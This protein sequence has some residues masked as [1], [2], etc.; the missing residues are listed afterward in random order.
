MS[1]SLVAPGSAQ[2]PPVP[3]GV[4]GFL[5]RLVALR[6]LEQDAVTGFL[7]S[8]ADRLADYDDVD[9]LGQTLV[10]CGLLTRYQLDRVRV[11]TTHGLVL[12]NYRVLESLGSG[13]MGLVFE[14]E[15]CLLR[16]RVAIKVVP[17]EED[18]PASVRQRFAAEMQLLAS[19]DHPHIVRALDAGE[20]PAGG[21]DQPGLSYLVMELVRGGDLEH[22]VNKHGPLPVEEACEFARQ[23]AIGLQAAHDRH[24]IHRDLKPSN[25]LRTF[26]GR[27]KL[28]DFGLARQCSSRLTDHRM[29]MGS[30]E[31]MPPEQ[32]HDAST[33]GQEAD[34]YGLGAVLFWLL[35][36]EPPHPRTHN[37]R[38]ALCQLR[39]ETPRLLRTL[40]ADAP[41]DLEELLTRMLERNP[42]R[43]PRGARAVGEALAHFVRSEPMPR[44]SPWR[45]VRPSALLVEDRPG[46]RVANRTVLE[47]LGCTPVIV[48]SGPRGL[49]MI[50][51]RAFELVL[52]DLALSGKEIADLCRRI[53]EQAR[54]DCKIIVVDAQ[55]ESATI[56]HLLNSGAD[57]VVRRSG[58]LEELPARVERALRIRKSQEEATRRIA[59]LIAAREALRQ[60]LDTRTADLV[61]AHD[62]LLFTMAK[63]AESRDGE[64]PGHLS[65]LQAYVAVLARYVVKEPGYQ[66]LSDSLFSNELIRCVPLHDIGKI[67][68]PEELLLKPGALNAAERILVETHPLIGDRILE[69][70][71]R[72]HGTSLEFLGMAR[73]IVRSHH[74]RWDGRGYP[75]RLSREAIPIAARLVGL[76]DVYDALRRERLHK[77]GLSHSLACM[78]IDERSPGQFDPS[79]LAAFRGC[80]S[81]FERIYVETRD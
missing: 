54:S 23:A 51:D 50:R 22:Y 75:D 77:P 39:E 63:M 1:A 4:S 81:E 48:D 40:R 9:R 29:L 62:A 10:R 35:T 7:E 18:V 65:R 3:A 12:G 61:R 42:A 30:L 57:D 11:G 15:H 68:L 14:A 49:E 25:L 76:A 45:L 20:V 31:F 2:A 52:L 41:A 43:R 33:V 71:A 70:L 72:E 21:N 46:L 69:A 44:F 32:S 64:T 34:I 36:G 79:L 60:S 24:L 58:D 8:H 27:I 73:T 59:N 55:D 28:V 13:G 47:D 6:L 53:R 80:H 67:G 56:G 16:S 37:L 5:R 66:G 26:D 78:V 19:L 38:Q 17:I 74:E